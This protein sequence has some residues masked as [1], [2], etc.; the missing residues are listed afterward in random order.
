MEE[1]NIILV[2][3][4]VLAYDPAERAM[5]DL[6]KNQVTFTA[7]PPDTFGSHAPWVKGACPHGLAK[8]GDNSHGIT[9]YSA[10]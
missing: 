9:W 3:Y 1:K 6:G 8:C 4:M 10:S 5:P 7:L 2:C